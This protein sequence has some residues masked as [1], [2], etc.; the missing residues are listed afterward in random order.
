MTQRIFVKTSQGNAAW[1]AA[2]GS[3]RSFALEAPTSPSVRESRSRH[4]SGELDAI[5]V[6][7]RGALALLAL[8]HRSV[9]HHRAV[10]EV[11]GDPS[12]R[13]NELRPVCS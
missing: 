1:I 3:L 10:D 7:R 2:A 8:G 6:E 5:A 13:L 11:P 4:P 12:R 9:Q